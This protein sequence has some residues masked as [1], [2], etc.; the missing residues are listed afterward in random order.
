MTARI[1]PFLNHI[2]ACNQAQI[3]GNRLPFFWRDEHI[4]WVSPPTANALKALGAHS[5]DQLGITEPTA[6]H[7]LAKTLAEHG[8]Y[9]PHHEDFDIRN[10][11]G[12]VIGQVDRGAIPVLGLAAEGI[13]LNGLVEKSDGSYLWVARRSMNKK[14]DPGKLD[15]LVA[16][17]M[18]TGLTPATTLIKEAEEEAGIPATLAEQATAVSRIHYAMER[19]EG[20]RRDVLHCYDLILPE[21]FIP[22]ANDGEVE[23]F[24]L[25]PLTEVFERVRTTQD[26]KFNVNLVL[27]DLFSRRGFFAPEENHLINKALHAA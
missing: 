1:T 9:K 8:L 20:L 11:N 27:I 2:S 18:S 17:G 19:P 25:L 26:F 14:L 22:T 6:L 13:H 4:G 21:T 15:H 12:D 10:A 3:P 23:S 24:H 7:P 5:G 16:G